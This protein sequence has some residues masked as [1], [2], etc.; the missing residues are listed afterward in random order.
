MDKEQ[1]AER[2]RAI[3][4]DLHEPFAEIRQ[5][6]M[7]AFTNSALNDDD[8]RRQARHMLEAINLLEIEIRQ[9]IDDQDIQSR[10]V[11]KRGND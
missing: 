6:Q 3:L 9:A 5:R 10:K 11:R 7:T 4:K 2:A 1:K 8:A